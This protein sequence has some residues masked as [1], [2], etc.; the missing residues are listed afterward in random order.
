M[1]KKVK[2]LVAIGIDCLIFEILV[3]VARKVQVIFHISDILILITF[4]PLLFI[5]VIN[6][7]C[8]FGYESI[9]KKIMNLKIYQNGER[10]TNKKILRK[11]IFE[12]WIGIPFYPI[13]ILTSGKS[14]SDE[15]LNIEVQ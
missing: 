8:L 3:E 14:L 11:R 4:F 5:L 6:K 13:Y 2:R 1:N 9:G 7:D 10:V 15:K 12:G